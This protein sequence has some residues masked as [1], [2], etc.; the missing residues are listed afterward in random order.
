MGQ[1][2]L[3]WRSRETQRGQQVAVKAL[4]VSKAQS[5]RAQ[6]VNAVITLFVSIKE[7]KNHHH[8]HSEQNERV[9]LRA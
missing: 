5:H 6:A 7:Q 8:H 9:L 3:V 1:D 2:V 4:P